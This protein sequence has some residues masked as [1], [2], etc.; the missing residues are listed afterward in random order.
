MIV[1]NR[2][3]KANP[4]L[5]PSLRED[6]RT[7]LAE[8]VFRVWFDDLRPLREDGEKLV[9]QAPNEFA[10]IWLCDNYR[11]LLE[12]RIAHLTGR[13]MAVELEAP[14]EPE[15]ED[16][17]PQSRTAQRRSAAIR[18]FDEADLI[19]PRNTFANFVIGPGNQLA[20]AACVAVANDPGRAYNPLFLYGATGLGK[21]HLLQ[22]VAH[23]A[24]GKRTR[25]KIVYTSTEKFTNEFIRAVQENALGKFREIYR[26]VDMLLIDDIHFLSGK[27]RIQEEFFYTFNELFESQRQICLCSDRPAAEISRLESRLVSRFQW[28]FVAD[29]QVPDLETRIAILRKKA[30]AMRLAL[31]EEVLQLLAE[32]VSTNVRRL[33]GALNRVAGYVAFSG[34]QINCEETRRLLQDIFREE[35]AKMVHI[36]QIQ[37][38][39]AEFY[40]VTLADLLGKKRPAGIAFPRQVAMYLCRL[41][42]TYSLQRIGSEF[43]GREHGTVIHACKTVEGAMEQDASVRNAVETIREMIR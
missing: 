3:E 22:A 7:L 23:G 12:K 11:G 30:L 28:G 17:P 25:I 21:T 2:E 15:P 9:L 4:G 18:K 42:T 27:E 40:K 13:T 35:A 38:Q 14:P 6:L 32:G 36:D 8:D 5:W 39:V 19:N 1:N 31:P 24:L 43:G 33:E 37:R 20:Q 34:R 16:A 41:L 26:R 10:A 29:I